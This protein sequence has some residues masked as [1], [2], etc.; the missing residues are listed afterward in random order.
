MEQ[1][2]SFAS[3]RFPRAGCK[4]PVCHRR[5]QSAPELI[6]NGR[7]TKQSVAD[8]L[9]FDDII[10]VEVEDEG[11]DI[12]FYSIVGNNAEKSVEQHIRD[13]NWNFNV[14]DLIFD[15][16]LVAVGLIIFACYPSLASICPDE[17]KLR[18]FLTNVSAHY[19]Q[20]LSYHNSQ[21]GTDVLHSTHCLLEKV[22]HT[23]PLTALDILSILIAAAVHDVQ[24]VGFSNRFL[25]QTNHPIYQ[26][27]SHM[28]SPLEAMHV[29]CG[30]QLVQ[31]PAYSLLDK[32]S[33]EDQRQLKQNISYFILGTDLACQ[34]E[35]LAVTADSSRKDHLRL[36]LHAADLGA[37]AKNRQIHDI[38][39][40]RI[41]EEFFQQGD[42]QR[43]K[44]L[45]VCSHC[46][47]NE[48]FSKIQSY[49]VMNLVQ[50]V[51]SVLKGLGYDVDQPLDLIAANV[52]YWQNEL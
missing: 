43:Q 31:D 15:D 39:S 11:E 42:L 41:M 51:Y 8:D 46:D 17:S 6:S 24:H 3:F 25:E 32:L 34:T 44:N 16:P 52:A 37:S 21:H 7:K 5:Y 23:M 28:K 10:D 4:A 30:L 35:V 26:K 14:A 45:P 47:R 33:L 50:P 12:E 9:D 2:P 20:N 48:S 13:R 19:D 22:I 38:W 40:R 29:D 49:F 27:Y 18:R 36:V 1:L